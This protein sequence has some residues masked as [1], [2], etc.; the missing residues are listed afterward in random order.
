MTF[1]HAE[2]TNSFFYVEID[3]AHSNI[4][5]VVHND[6]TGLSCRI[7]TVYHR[8]DKCCNYSHFEST[9]QCYTQDQ[10]DT[11]YLPRNEMFCFIAIATNISFRMILEGAFNTNDN[12]SGMY[13]VHVILHIF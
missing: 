7:Q 4:N 10:L 8:D 3:P 1:L 13:N 11:T 5:C 2:S 6:I 9:D 12:N